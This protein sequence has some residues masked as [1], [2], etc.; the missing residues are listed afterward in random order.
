MKR[1]IDKIIDKIETRVIY[2][3][4]RKYFDPIIPE[5]EG[6]VENHSFESNCGIALEGWYIKGQQDKP[7]ILYCHGLA[8]NIAFF[9]KPYKI[10]SENGY[11]VFAGEYRAH[12]NS[13]AKGI[14]P[15]ETG[16]YEDVDSA[17][18]Y[19]QN[20]IGIS[21]E[22][23]IIW[24]RSMGG[25]IAAHAATKYNFKAVILESTFT[26]IQEASDYVVKTDSQHPVFPPYKKLFMRLSKYLPLKQKFDTASKIHKIKSPLLIAH[27]KPDM[28]VDYRMAQKN[29]RLHG[30]ARLFIS[31]EGSHEHSDWV[32]GEVLDFLQ[33]L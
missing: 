29:A 1:L 25:A 28:I 4:M 15:S 16:I 32:Y 13:R 8:E 30:S 9:Q 24:G 23:I 2:Y 10:L 19:L 18:E 20:K 5:L 26:N 27:S 22:N 3:P 33:K 17:V 11:G 31:E 6:S 12:G 7:V 21:E 14:I